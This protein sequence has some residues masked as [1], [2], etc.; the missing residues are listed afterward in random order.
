MQKK[1]YNS[2]EAFKYCLLFTLFMFIFV[3]HDIH[4]TIYNRGKDKEKD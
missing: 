1:N 3:E 2:F 4:H